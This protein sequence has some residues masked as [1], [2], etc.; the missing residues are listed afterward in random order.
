MKIRNKIIA[1]MI[2]LI[3]IPTFALAK[4]GPYAGVK[5]AKIDVDYKTVDGV[6]LNRLFPT[7]FNAWDIHLGYNLGNGFFEFGY[8]NSNN[9]SKNLGSTNFGSVTLSANTSLDFDGY[10]IGAGYNFPVSKEFVIKPFINYYEIDL[11]ASGTLTVTSGST[12][13]SATSTVSGT[14]TMIDA[15]VGFDYLVNDRTKISLS[16]ARTLDSLDDTNKV[17]TLALSANYQF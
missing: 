15:G 4:D 13:V 10:R 12:T 3:A 2:S 16:Y 17:Q 14:D 1:L 7:D 9:E 8:I 11:S 6:D 5:Y